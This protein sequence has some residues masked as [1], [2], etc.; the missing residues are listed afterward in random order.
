[1]CLCLCQLITMLCSPDNANAD[2]NDS[3]VKCRVAGDE[4]GGGRRAVVVNLLV[5]I[6]SHVD[7][8]PLR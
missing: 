1:M 8:S 3:P 7:V 4:A 5:A 2:A 6:K